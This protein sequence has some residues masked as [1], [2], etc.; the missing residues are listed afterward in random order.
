MLTGEPAEPTAGKIQG[1]VIPETAT[2]GVSPGPI[3][4]VPV[5]SLD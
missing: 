4:Q 5:L 2:P 3:S 1:A